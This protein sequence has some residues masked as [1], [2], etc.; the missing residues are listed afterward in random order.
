M[1]SFK[2]ATK[3]K[4]KR[5]LLFV[6]PC[7]KRT[8]VVTFYIRLVSDTK[9]I[10][11]SHENRLLV[12]RPFRS[13]DSTET[14]APVVCEIYLSLSYTTSPTLRAMT[15]IRGSF[16]FSLTCTYELSYSLYTNLTHVRHACQK[17]IMNIPSIQ[18]KHSLYTHVRLTT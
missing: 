9:C 12:A 15:V 16:C 6:R 1:R 8:F 2:N 7:K 10:A 3:M 11:R 14:A 13:R 5:L 17:Q 4:Q 18:K